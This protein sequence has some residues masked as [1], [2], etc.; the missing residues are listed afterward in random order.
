M[1][2]GPEIES[3]ENA[4]ARL[5]ISPDGLDLAWIEGVRTDTERAVAELRRDPRFGGALPATAIWPELQW[6]ETT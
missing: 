2:H 6:R 3:L 4:L 5:G 1:K